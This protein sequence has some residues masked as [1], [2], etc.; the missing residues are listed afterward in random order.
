MKRIMEVIGWFLIGVAWG[1]VLA[2][3][4]IC[5]SPAHADC[6]DQDL[7]TGL[8]ISD[9][10]DRCG[11]PVTITR[12]SA[13]EIEFVYGNGDVIDFHGGIVQRLYTRRNRSV[14]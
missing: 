5:P 2:L 11:E 3:V 9:V 13:K 12:P 8:G 10:L 6:A 4:F 14:K 1:V 7:D